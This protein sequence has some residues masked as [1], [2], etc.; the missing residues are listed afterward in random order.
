MGVLESSHGPGLCFKKTPMSP[1]AIKGRCHGSFLKS[2]LGVCS[3]T[4]KGRH[5]YTEGVIGVLKSSHESQFQNPVR[6]IPIP[7]PPPYTQAT[8]KKYIY[9]F[10]Y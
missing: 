9:F 1:S 10:L 3:K 4:P 2:S 5:E 8:N 6:A 7:P